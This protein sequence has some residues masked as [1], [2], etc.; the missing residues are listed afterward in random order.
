[1]RRD[2]KHVANV[3][4]E[5]LLK[6]K[7]WKRCEPV[8]NPGKQGLDI[9]RSHIEAVLQLECVAGHPVD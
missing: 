5:V 6:P 4:F 8:V 7:R 2:L 9:H 1:M 3:E